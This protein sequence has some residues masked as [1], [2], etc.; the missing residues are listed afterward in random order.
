MLGRWYFPV[1]GTEITKQT[2]AT[3][4]ALNFIHNHLPQ[5]QKLKGKVKSFTVSKV[6]ICPQFSV[7]A[8]SVLLVACCYV[9]YLL[10][11]GTFFLWKERYQYV[12]ETVGRTIIFLTKINL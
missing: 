1:Q 4:I 10:I 5:W 12:D 6:I 9:T 7:A 8:D 11:T 2:A 3:D